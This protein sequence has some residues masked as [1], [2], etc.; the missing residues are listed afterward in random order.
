MQA[1]TEALVDAVDEEERLARDEAQLEERIEEE[2]AVER[3][4]ADVKLRERA[5][6]AAR[7]LGLPV[8][9]T[10]NDW[11]SRST[12]MPATPDDPL[13]MLWP[14]SGALDWPA[15]LA[16]RRAPVGSAPAVTLSFISDLTAA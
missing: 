2:E 10:R 9:V 16:R 5:V 3:A 7:D 14:A 13:I 4:D 12:P 11:L 6:A 15:F 1:A 8:L